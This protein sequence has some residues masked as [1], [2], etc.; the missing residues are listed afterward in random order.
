[1]LDTP[2]QTRLSPLLNVIVIQF[3]LVL[4]GLEGFLG[5]VPVYVQLLV[6]VILQQPLL[7]D[8]LVEYLVCTL[9]VLQI[10]VILMEL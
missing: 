9:V 4:T 3:L 2:L 8:G 6:I 10:I 1:M 5:E 7:E